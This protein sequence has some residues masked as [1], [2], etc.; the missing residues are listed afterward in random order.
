LNILNHQNDTRSL[1]KEAA[2]SITFNSNNSIL[3]LHIA[4]YE[5][6]IENAANSNE[7]ND[8]NNSLKNISLEKSWKDVKQ[9]FNDST[10]KNPYE[11]PRQQKEEENKPEVMQFKASQ[12]L[13]NPYNPFL[14]KQARKK[15]LNLLEKFYHLQ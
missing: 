1:D 10:T 5:N 2:G 11:I 12:R 8:S 4:A 3:S 9:F 13:S 6:A 14:K 7:Q 15:L